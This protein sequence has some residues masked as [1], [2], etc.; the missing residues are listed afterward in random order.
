ML[1]IKT[2]VSIIDEVWWSGVFTRLALVEQEFHAET[3]CHLLA[4]CI[5]VQ[6]HWDEGDGHLPT[7][8]E[9]SLSD[10]K[11]LKTKSLELK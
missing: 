7:C 5:G 8:K 9:L 10:C 2:F 11:F 4:F 6:V 1:I 3:G